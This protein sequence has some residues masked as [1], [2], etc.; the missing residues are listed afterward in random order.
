MWLLRIDCCLLES[1]FLA[2]SFRKGLKSCC[3]WPWSNPPRVSFFSASFWARL[4]WLAWSTSAATELCQGECHLL[5]QIFSFLQECQHSSW[6][7]P[8]VLGC[9]VMNHIYFSPDKKAGVAGKLNGT[10]EQAGSYCCQ[11]RRVEGYKASSKNI[12]DLEKAEILPTYF[13]QLVVRNKALRSVVQCFTFLFTSVA[14]N[15]TEDSYPVLTTEVMM[16]QF[17]VF[18]LRKAQPELWL[19]EE[20][21]FCMVARNSRYY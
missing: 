5:V 11:L 15:G 20:M 17:V 9:G 1:Y 2:G 4:S 18:L 16:L 6:L 3:L 14:I 21:T 13:L 19:S 10:A 12:P 7:L 8:S